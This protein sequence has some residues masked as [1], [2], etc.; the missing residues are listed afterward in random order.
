[1]PHAAK[2]TEEHMAKQTVPKTFRIMACLL[3]IFARAWNRSY[4]GVRWKFGF[5]IL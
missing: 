2:K 5:L 4:T 1:M 3:C